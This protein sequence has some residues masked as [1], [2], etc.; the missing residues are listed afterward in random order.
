MQDSSGHTAELAARAIKLSWD[1]M[2]HILDMLNP[3]EED[4]FVLHGLTCDN[5]GGAAIQHL[6]PQLMMLETMGPT[7]KM[8]GCDMHNFVKPLEVACADAWGR[9]GIGHRTPF[10]M[11][12]LFAKIMKMV[13]IQKHFL[14]ITT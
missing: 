8:L 12:W 9:Q 1:E 10:Q 6:H 2:A 3:S 13:T 4:K 14:Q 11:M 7:S 5:G